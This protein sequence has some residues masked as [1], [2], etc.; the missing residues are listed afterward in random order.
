MQQR[1]RIIVLN[2]GINVITYKIFVAKRID[3]GRVQVDR[4]IEAKKLNSKFHKSKKKPTNTSGDDDKSRKKMHCAVQRIGGS[5][6]LWKMQN[7]NLRQ[8][9]CTVRCY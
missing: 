3:K 7:Q 4:R 8:E 1:N 5:E 2:N 6:W 9:H